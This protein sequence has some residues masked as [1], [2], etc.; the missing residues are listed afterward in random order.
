MT[1]L[2]PHFSLAELCFSSTATRLGLNNTPGP[3]VVEN[4]RTTA[5][6][7][8][9]VRQHLNAN[10]VRISSGYRCPQL[11]RVLCESSYRTWCSRR[12]YA[13]DASSWADYL[14]GKDHP[15]GRAVDFISPTYGSPTQI[16]RT[17]VRS[18]IEFDQLILEYPASNGWVHISF[19]DEN[20]R[21]QVLVV[22]SIGT[23]QFV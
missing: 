21:H 14:L 2:S 18:G 5:N 9:R 10:A 17:L 8:E 20:P 7:L 15:K 3:D 1:Q 13:V 4:L 19:A 23:R 12:G 11:E 16:V 6:G 22:D